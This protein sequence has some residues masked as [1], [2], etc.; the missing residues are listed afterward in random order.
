MS[1]SSCLFRTGAHLTVSEDREDTRQSAI[2]RAGSGL[3]GW[4][5][6][7]TATAFFSFVVKEVFR[8]DLSSEFMFYR[9]YNTV[10][11]DKS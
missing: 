6:G 7:A 3:E 9:A 11:R 8:L 2:E 4:S 1:G 10:K 5:S